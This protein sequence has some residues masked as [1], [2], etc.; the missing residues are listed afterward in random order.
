MLSAD[1][2]RELDTLVGYFNKNYQL[3][4]RQVKL[5]RYTG[6]GDGQDIVRN[7]AEPDAIQVVDVLR[8]KSGISAAAIGAPRIRARM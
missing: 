2:R 1:R 6:R 5:V 3:Y 8:F 7:S 4:G